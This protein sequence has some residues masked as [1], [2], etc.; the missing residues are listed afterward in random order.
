MIILLG[1]L[2]SA[3]GLIRVSPGTEVWVGDTL[4]IECYTQGG[5]QYKVIWAR[6]YDEEKLGHDQHDDELLSHDEHDKELLAHDEQIL[7]DD[8][9]IQ[10]KTEEKDNHTVSTLQASIRQFYFFLPKLLLPSNNVFFVAL[11]F[12]SIS[13]SGFI[14]YFRYPVH[15]YLIVANTPVF[16]QVMIQKIPLRKM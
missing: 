8:A 11:T 6:E 10:V 12:T 13:Y 15:Y 14:S 4:T 3:G 9:R 2:S 16:Y 5:G 1:V 7:L